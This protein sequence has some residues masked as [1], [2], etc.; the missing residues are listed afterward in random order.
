[1]RIVHKKYGTLV[2]GIDMCSESVVHHTTKGWALDKSTE[3]SYTNTLVVQC[4][5]KGW[6]VQEPHM[7]SKRSI[8]GLTKSTPHV[9]N[10]KIDTVP[11]CMLA[12]LLTSEAQLGNTMTSV[13]LYHQ[14]LFHVISFC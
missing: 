13:Y 5:M 3:A 1:M 11:E 14:R 2:H 10:A 6:I 12:H 8:K 4:R 7:Y 9:K